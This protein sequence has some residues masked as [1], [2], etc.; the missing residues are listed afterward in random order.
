MPVSTATSNH[1][2]C[3]E[4]SAGSLDA[5]IAAETQKHE[6]MKTR[7]IGLMQQLF[8]SPRRIES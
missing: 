3:Y 8:P 5:L 4:P 1:C 7:K 2:S 6:A